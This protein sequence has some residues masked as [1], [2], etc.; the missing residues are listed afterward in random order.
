M[1]GRGPA[2]DSLPRTF[3]EVGA[4]FPGLK[5]AVVSVPLIVALP[6]TLKFPP[7]VRPNAERLLPLPVEE[8]SGGRIASRKVFV[9][10]ICGAVI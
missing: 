1:C 8:T 9:P 5:F 2:T 3:R 10:V 6:A 4:K 7:S